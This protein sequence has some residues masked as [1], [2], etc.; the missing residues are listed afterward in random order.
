MN[1]K[2]PCAPIFARACFMAM[3]IFALPALSASADWKPELLTPTQGGF[4]P[5]DT[6]RITL[7]KLSKET[8]RR[9]VLELDDIDVTGMLSHAGNQLVF[10][11]PQPMAFGQ[12]RLRLIEYAADGSIIERGV[13][14]LEIRQTSLFR[15]A[16]L[17]GNATLN[18]THRIADDGLNNLPSRNQANGA[19]QLSGALADSDW[20]LSGNADLLGNT[21]EDQMPRLKNHVDIGHFLVTGQT[22]PLTVNAGHHNIAPDNLVMQGFNRRGVSASLATPQGGASITGFGLHGEDI[23]GAQKGVG[24]GDP[25]NR[26]NGI[27]TSAHPISS[28]REALFLSAIYLSGEGPNQ[29]GVSAAGDPT[30]AGGRAGSLIADGN[31]FQKHVRVRGE[32]AAT[33][34]DFDGSHSGNSAQNDQAYAVLAIF[35]PWH[36][37]VVKGQPMATSVGVEHKRIG[38]FFRSPAAPGA[39]AD[40]EILRRFANFDWFGVNAQLSLGNETDNVDDLALLPRT[41]TT[42]G[43][44]SLSYAPLQTPTADGQLPPPAWYGQPTYNITYVDVTQDV[45]KAGATL[46]RGA[47]HATRHVTLSAMFIYSSWNWSVSHAVGKDEDFTNTAP[48]TENR[49]TQL[50]ANVIIGEKLSIGPTVQL[51]EVTDKN[52]NN[53]NSET[54]TAGLNLSYAFSQRVNGN[55]G[56]SVNR[57]QVQDGSMKIRSHDIIGGL[58]WALRPAQGL[59]PGV[60]LS[61][62]GQYHDTEDRVTAANNQNNYQVFVKASVSWQAGY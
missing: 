34:F 16:Q 56:Y 50:G 28:D 57:Q 3:S 1:K 30:V 49:M 15:E 27:V 42:Q 7:P 55:L 47:L 9:L 23:Y 62:E 52:N 40:R 8:L 18:L 39:T 26:V 45:E 36:Q 24:I 44:V 32:Y 13:W 21:Q 22:G 11:P 29:L 5:A 51:N 6:I 61:L 54:I 10:T 43:V 41:E 37:Q 53:Q 33:E 19:M 25:G 31:L 4:G 38:T 12:H 60:A 20:R 35:T 58:I 17:Q 59:K 14:V 48:D 46:A 2:T